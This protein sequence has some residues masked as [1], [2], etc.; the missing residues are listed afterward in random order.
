MLKVN[1]VAAIEEFVRVIMELLEEMTTTLGGNNYLTVSPV[2]LLY[3]TVKN[4]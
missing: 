3:S 1:E 2:L 4:I